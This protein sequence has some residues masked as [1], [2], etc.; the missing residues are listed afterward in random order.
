[1]V[2]EGQ[3]LA[4]LLRQALKQHYGPVWVCDAPG[5]IEEEEALAGLIGDADTEAGDVPVKDILLGSVFR[6]LI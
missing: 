2:L 1:M 4:A 6:L 3:R 5:A